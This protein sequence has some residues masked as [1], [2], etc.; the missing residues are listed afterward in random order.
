LDVLPQWIREI[1]WKAQTRLCSRFRK[2]L[3]RGKN[4]NTV[5]TATA[6]ELA[7]FMW[8]IAWAL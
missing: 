1:A 2:L 5:I 6:R 3:A 4:R 8:A 7:A